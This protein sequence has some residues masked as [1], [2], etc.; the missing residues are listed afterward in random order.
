MRK[1]KIL[2]CIE[3]I[4]QGGIPK[5]LESLFHV[6]DMSEYDIGLFCI[7]SI[8]GAYRDSLERYLKYKQNRI[9]YYLSTYYKEHT[10]LKK[11]FLIIIKTLSKLLNILFGFNL[12]EYTLKCCAKDI[13]KENY[14][15]VVAYS[16]GVITKFVSQIEK[17]KKIAWIHI[18]YKRYLEYFPQ[19]N[20]LYTYSVYDKIIIPS[21]FSKK[22]FIDTYPS[23]REKVYVIQNLLDV[24]QTLLN[25]NEFSIIEDKFKTDNFKILSVG[26]ICYEKGVDKIP[27][28]AK[29]LK[30]RGNK[31]Q[32]FIIGSGSDIETNHLLS[33]IKKENVKDCVI[34]LGAKNNPYPYIK[35]SNLIAITSIS[36]TFSYVI[37]EAK[38]IG[39]PIITTDFG[40]VKE[41]MS[42][43]YGIIS[44]INDFPE[45]IHKIINN[46]QL[47]SIL[48]TNIT[49]YQH[50]NSTTLQKLYSI[51]DK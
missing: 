8:D 35:N 43:E 26:R 3:N 42:E 12:F 19:T 29:E 7:N 39:T 27:K 28:I 33:E 22:S 1:R 45:N 9:L 31:F 4:R 24:K 34:L 15:I 16:E 2:F 51:F 10:G 46:Q 14:D 25:A 20:E 6:L 18:D 38:I 49:K 5:A 44:S 40:T 47:Y 41:V 48:K 11:Y 13:S 36:E 50:N 37:A 21:I 32:W 23:L 30:K 17:A